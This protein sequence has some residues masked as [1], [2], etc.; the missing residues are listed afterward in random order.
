MCFS[1]TASF[2]AS[3]LLTTIGVV[4]L[5]KSKN[6][7]QLMFVCIPFVFAIQQF[8][9]GFVWIAL[10]H[11]AGYTAQQVAINFFLAFAL[12]VWP[13][14][15]PLS[16]LF[17]ETR[18][19][20]R[21]ILSVFAGMGVLFSTLSLYYLL[22]YH[23]RA[24]ITDFHICYELDI[25]FGGKILLGFL[26]LVP[27]VLSLFVSSVKRVPIMGVM[28]LLSY[29]ITKLFFKDYVISVWCF[30]AAIISVMIYFVLA[31]RAFWFERNA[32]LKTSLTI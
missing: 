27:T 7:N 12:I 28:V 22:A 23:S 13:A 9:E 29:L 6:V 2:T 16:I 32:E 5:R 18:L 10:S 24:F 30:F 1:T 26:Y 19:K 31:D 17:I 4:S 25:P 15:I 11:N 21:I 14:W 20:R 8:S 3:A